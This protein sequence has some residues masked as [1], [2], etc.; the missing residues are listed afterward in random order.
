MAFITRISYSSNHSIKT[1]VGK[2]EQIALCVGID[3][4]SYDS[5]DKTWLLQTGD[6]LAYQG[7]FDEV[8][9]M[10]WDHIIDPTY[11]EA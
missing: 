10:A 2:L 8:I 5:Q 1:I 7:K 6:G 9:K 11:T 3:G 4:L